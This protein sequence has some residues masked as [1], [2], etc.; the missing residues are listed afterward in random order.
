LSFTNFG[1]DLARRAGEAV[2]QEFLL[3]RFTT[4][5]SGKGKP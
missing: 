4:H 5:V 1:I 2:I 3:K